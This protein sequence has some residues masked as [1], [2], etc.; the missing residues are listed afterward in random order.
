MNI[1]L[2]GGT[3]FIGSALARLLVQDG[4]SLV[5]L[6]RTPAQYISSDE[7]QYIGALSEVSTEQPIHAVI[8]LAGQPLNGERWNA[9]YK[10][11]LIDSR[12]NTTRRLVEWIKQRDTPPS[13]LISGSAIGWYGNQP[14]KMLSESDSFSPGF[15][16]SLCEAWEQEALAAESIDTRVCLIRTGIVLDQDG[17]PLAAMPDYPVCPQPNPTEWPNQWHRPYACATARVCPP[18]G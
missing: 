17:G 2:T 15:T 6:T 8:N 9:A 4:H 13:V 11:A 18:A 10:Q 16:H 12:I 14:D 1:L 5:I 3:G 7:L